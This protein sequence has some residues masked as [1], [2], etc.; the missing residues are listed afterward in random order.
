MSPAASAVIVATEPFTCTVPSGPSGSTDDNLR[1]A[2]AFA[3]A[4]ALTTLKGVGSPT[5]TLSGRSRTVGAGGAV[6]VVGVV[7]A[8]VVVVVILMAIVAD[9]FPSLSSLI[10]T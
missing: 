4:S 6:G 1:F 5:N 3:A 7:G 2:P 10:V 8:G 9:T